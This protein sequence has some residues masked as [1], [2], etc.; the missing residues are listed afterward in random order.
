METSTNSTTTLYSFF[1]YMHI[2]KK[3]STEVV[4]LPSSIQRGKKGLFTSDFVKKGVSW[5]NGNSTQCMLSLLPL[6]ILEFL[7]FW[8]LCQYSKTYKTSNKLPVL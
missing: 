1:L 5:L 6:D 4:L 8:M 3:L 7:E 2:L